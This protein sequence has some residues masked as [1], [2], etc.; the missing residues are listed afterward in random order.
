MVK[1]QGELP[2]PV[3]IEFVF[4]FLSPYAYLARFGLVRL[5]DRYGAQIVYTPV[6]LQTLKLQV[7]NTGPANRDIPVK[8]RHLRL[9]LRRWADLYQV[10]FVPPSGYG[11]ERLN[12]G[13]LF[14]A[15]AGA[16]DR[17]VEVAWDE[18][19]GKGGDMGDDELLGRVAARMGW[20][21]A[22]LIGFARS[23]AAASRLREQTRACAAR[24][25]F[26]VPTM[27]IGEEMWWGNDRLQFVEAYLKEGF[28]A[29]KA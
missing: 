4:D 2:V 19:W 23:P 3:Q 18:V 13:A 11:P 27:L 20:D 15:D 16:A 21:P 5:A 12:C 8:H 28:H 1:A 25:I 10:P 17:Y 22:E 14:A 26:G 7:G 24:G 29:E 6:D 9:D